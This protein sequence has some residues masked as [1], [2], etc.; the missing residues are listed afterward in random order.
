MR[1][2]TYEEQKM[3]E[4]LIE[5]LKILKTIKVRDKVLH[6]IDAE[7]KIYAELDIKISK[8]KD[9]GIGYELIEEE[10]N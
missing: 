10:L 9:I 8:Y 6:L 2:M 5:P 7:Q 3:I 1:Q 4:K